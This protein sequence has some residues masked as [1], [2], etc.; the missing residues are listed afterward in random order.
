MVQSNSVLAFASTS[1]NPITSAITNFITNNTDTSSSDVTSPSPTP[2]TDPITSPI[3]DP[4][5]TPTPTSNPINSAVTTP[6]PT[7]QPNNSSNNSASTP[8]NNTNNQ[9]T[10]CT[11]IKPRTAPKLLKAY[12]S[13]KNQVKLEWS[14]G[15]NPFT[16]YL[17]AYG[18]KP[19][20]LEYGNPN[21]GGKNTTSYVVSGLQNGRTY[22]FRIRAG[23]N[24]APGDFSNELSVKVQGDEIKNEVAV[25]FHSAVLG[26]KQI[27]LPFKPITA[28]STTHISNST[29]TFI[30]SLWDLLS[31]FVLH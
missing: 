1:D 7:P 13:G 14:Q 6:S 2:T 23:N 15:E 9:D 21:I 24:C 11:D 30:A 22:Y 5:P 29:F 17:V 19:G 26:S 27:A 16:Y 4:T 31:K 28:A 8:S 10:V 12:L 25:G 18:S 3:A 20:V